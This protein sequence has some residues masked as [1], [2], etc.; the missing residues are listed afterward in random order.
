MII[1]LF[2][3][4]LGVNIFSG[5]ETH[6]LYLNNKL[7]WSGGGTLSETF[8]KRHLPIFANGKN[9]EHQLVPYLAVFVACDY[10]VWQPK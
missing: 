7:V 10:C 9:K 8:V 2:P 6:R 3:Q 4:L 5:E 1:C